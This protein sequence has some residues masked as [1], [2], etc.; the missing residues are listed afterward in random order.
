M[1]KIFTNFK[2]ANYYAKQLPNK[3]N[4]KLIREGDN[5]MVID[6]TP[7]VKP[8][9]VKSDHSP[10][11]WRALPV[12]NKKTENINKAK[13]IQ[14]F[15]SNWVV[16]NDGFGGRRDAVRRMRAQDRSD[17][18]K[19]GRRAYSAWISRQTSLSQLDTQRDLTV[20]FK[21]I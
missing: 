13:T 15:V 4:I 16:N 8:Q 9:V 19:R 7:V 14:T 1:S 17:M 2:D 10:A 12:E 20:P 18:Q 3:K 6:K 21:W 5:W 11:K